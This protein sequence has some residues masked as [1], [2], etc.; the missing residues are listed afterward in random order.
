MECSFPHQLL[1][2]PQRKNKIMLSKQG[3]R[4]DGIV[5]PIVALKIGRNILQQRMILS[6]SPSWIESAN[7]INSS[8]Y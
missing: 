4:L 8:P 7:S 5:R 3:E 6:P 2:H 1:L